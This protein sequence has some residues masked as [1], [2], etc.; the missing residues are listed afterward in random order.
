MSARYLVGGAFITSVL[1]IC[2]VAVAADSGAGSAIVG[3][4]DLTIQQGSSRLPSWIG[5][6]MKDGKLDGRFVGTGG[7]VSDVKDLKFEDGKLAFVGG[8]QQFEATVKGDDLTGE[9]G[10][11]NGE[12]TKFVGKRFVPK[13]ETKAQ[14]EWGEPIK[15]FDGTNL[16]GWELIRREKGMGNW[17]ME[18]GVLDNTKSGPNIRT[19]R[20]FKDFK[21]HI[22]FNVPAHGNSGVYLRGRY[23][24]QV[25]DSFEEPLG[26]GSCGALYGRIAPSE[27]VCKK[28]GEW[29]SFDITLVGQ[30]VTVLQNGRTIIDNKEVE[31]ITGGALNSNEYAPGPIYLQGDHT[32]V[33]YR[34]IVLTPA[35]TTEKEGAAKAGQR[36]APR[37]K[38][39]APAREQ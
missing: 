24:I 19:K 2:G 9:V 33:K 22:E 30:R 38:A 15:L 27:N 12:K 11:K 28:P 3:R 17:K 14:P 10:R 7:G 16:D 18:E 39:K 32:S 8:G 35:K 13:P 37:K 1:A 25:A 20:M 26:T 5:I 4:W 29:Q 36:N 23:E 6:T 34:N 31:G 21:L